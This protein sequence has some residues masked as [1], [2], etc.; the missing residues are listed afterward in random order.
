MLAGIRH[1]M[2]A[3]RNPVLGLYGG[4]ASSAVVLVYQTSIGAPIP[5]PDKVTTY[6]AGPQGGVVGCGQVNAGPGVQC[7]WV[8]P[9]TVGSILLPKS[10][11]PQALDLLRQLR[12]SVEP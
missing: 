8:D 11:Q 5:V 4:P 7:T 12:H 10:T 1:T 2:P 6:P 9:K 3:A